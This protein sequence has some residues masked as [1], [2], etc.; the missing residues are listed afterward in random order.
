MTADRRTSAIPWRQR[1]LEALRREW[2]QCEWCA[3]THRPSPR[4][5]LETALLRCSFRS[6]ERFGVAARRLHAPTHGMGARCADASRM[7]ACARR[8][9]RHSRRA[10]SIRLQRCG[11]DP[12]MRCRRSSG[13]NSPFGALHWRTTMLAAVSALGPSHGMAADVLCCAVARGLLLLL[14]LCQRPPPR[15]A[16]PSSPPRRSM[17]TRRLLAPSPLA[18]RCWQRQR[19]RR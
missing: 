7:A 2:G 1:T 4:R 12:W 13:C 5:P 16:R 3:R 15:R 10:A 8:T 17:P 19:P 6:A 9:R 18:S 14:F 11:C